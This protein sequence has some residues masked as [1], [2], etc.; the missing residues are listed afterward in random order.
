MPILDI[1]DEKGRLEEQRAWHEILAVML[2]PGG[3]TDEKA[4]AAVRARQQ[5]TARLMEQA[6]ATILAGK[7]KSQPVQSPDRDVLAEYWLAHLFRFIARQHGPLALAQAPGLSSFARTVP[8]R[9]RWGRMAGNLL[10]VGAVLHLAGLPSGL[11]RAAFVMAKMMGA[12]N[13]VAQ[14]RTLKQNAWGDDKPAVHLWAALL[15][16]G[17]GKDFADEPALP[18]G[19]QGGVVKFLG[20]AEE[21]FRLASTEIKARNEPAALLAGD[22]SV[23]TVPTELDLPRIALAPQDLPEEVIRISE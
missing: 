2:Y 7:T 14:I 21:Y 15:T 11:N 18:F 12:T 1:L 19:R 10:H 20:L 16:W 9:A 6:G 4:A 17:L 13:V 5:F 23:W 22:D 3:L 8:T